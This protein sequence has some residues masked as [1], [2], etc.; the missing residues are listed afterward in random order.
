M[1]PLKISLPR[2]KKVSGVILGIAIAAGLGILIIHKII[3]L[4]QMPLTSQ[5]PGIPV[6][7]AVAT[8]GPISSTIEYNGTVVSDHEVAVA[9]RVMAE[10]KE[11]TVN[12]G[13]TVKKGQV[14]AV[15]DSQDL[16]DKITQAEAGVAQAGAAVEQAEANLANARTSFVTTADNYKR[17]R[18]LLDAGAISR[19]TFDTQYDLPY[20]QAQQTAEHAAP[21]QLM[22][23]E[24]Q[25]AQARAA[26][27]LARSAYNDSVI[28]APFD[29]VIT[30]IQNYPG[31]LAV[32][33]KP[34]L[35]M[36]DTGRLKVQ[37]KVIAVD[38]SALHEG[39]VA[40]VSFP[41]LSLKPIK[42]RVT[43]I[44]PSADP[45][46]HTT[47]VEIPLPST[48][49]KP[50]MNAQISFILKSQEYALLVPRPAIKTDNNHSYVFTVKNN[51]AVQV[52]VYTGIEDENYCAVTGHIKPGDR[53]IVSDLSKL[54]N[55]KEV[56]LIPERSQP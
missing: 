3:S 29:G 47:V 10:I 40:L 6:E 2:F 56:F 41:D 43:R 48:R 21:A 15:L 8:T 36:A 54:S 34:I 53:V 11:V 32:P 16:K 55:G 46:F 19:A 22:Q 20:R 13:D 5:V 52:P 4:Q 18:A 14:L 27:A 17:G 7:T 12:T 39:T 45:V 28:K 24:A 1:L 49:A 50:G 37:V 25:L 31:D 9:A 23:A 35:T 30:S 38:L 44:Y 26:L 33:G 42:S 51:R